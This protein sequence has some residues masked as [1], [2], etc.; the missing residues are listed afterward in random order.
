[1]YNMAK[2]RKIIVFLTITFIDTF[3]LN[4]EI[5]LMCNLL[6][7]GPQNSFPHHQKAINEQSNKSE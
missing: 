6:K 7:N 1:M 3:E 5:V 4:N 2:F